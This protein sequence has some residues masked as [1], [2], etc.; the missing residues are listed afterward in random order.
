MHHS[1][2]FFYF[3][4]NSHLAISNLCCS[5]TDFRRLLA[6]HVLLA[7]GISTK[8][9]NAYFYTLGDVIDSFS[10]ISSST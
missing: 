4:R 2:N 3:R 1:V 5:L 6:V 8:A 9:L 7:I 10:F